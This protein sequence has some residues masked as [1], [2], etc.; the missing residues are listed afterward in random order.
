MLSSF[1]PGEHLVRRRVGRA[2]VVLADD[3]E[4]VAVAGDGL[5]QGGGVRRVR[6][7]PLSAVWLGHS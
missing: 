1:G 2:G 7:L 5:A 4:G 3:G 6:W